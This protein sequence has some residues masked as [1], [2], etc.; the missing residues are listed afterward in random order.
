M[1]KIIF[2]GG[3]TGGHIY[4]ALAIREIILQRA[5]NR[6]KISS[7]YIGLSNS[8]EA[9]I[10]A[11]YSDIPFLSIRAQGMPR[12]FTWKWIPFPFVNLFGAIDAIRHLREFAPNLVVATGG[13]VTFPVLLAARLMKIPYI[14]HEQNVI[15]GV[16]N[17]MFVGGARKIL[18]SYPSEA[19]IRKDRFAFTGN[20]VRKEFLGQS[21]INGLFHKKAGEFWILVVGGSRGAKSINDACVE[22]SERWLPEHQ[23]VR[24]LQITG[25]RDFEM[26]K[27]RISNGT[28]HFVYPYI[29]EMK[30]AFDVAD[31]LIS[32]A[33][34]TILSELGVCAKPAILIPFPYATDNHQEKN[35]RA[36]EQIGAA[37]VILDKELNEKSLRFLL[38]EVMNPETLKRMG[39]AMQ[40]SRPENVEERIYQEISPFLAN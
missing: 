19:F 33:G 7:A 23:N 12:E 29:H 35:A 22:L 28:R 32:R 17:R 5:P 30:E 24:L 3:G 26:I 37:R 10:L 21:H 39:I 16:T 1:N 27:S 6:S 18:L 31:I 2:C 38:H 4:P 36:L 20:P 9:H 14:I 8:M 25:E 11:K 13:Y 40:K 15:M 34:A